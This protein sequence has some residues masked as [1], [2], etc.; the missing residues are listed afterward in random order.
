MY[1]PIIL[2]TGLAGYTQL[3]RT[4]DAQQENYAKSAQVARDTQHFK[5]KMA[6]VQTVDDLM[7]DR[8][9][10]RVALGAFG[11]DEDLN[12]RAYIRKILESDLNDSK[13]LANRLADKRYLAFAKAFNFSGEAPNAPATRNATDVAL[14]LST[15]RKVDDLLNDKDLLAATLKTVGI[16]DGLNND[17]FLRKVLTSD[18][19]DPTSFVNRL[20]DSRYVELAEAFDFPSKAPRFD[21]VFGFV[22]TFRGR[23]ED[24]QTPEDLLGDDELLETALGIFGLEDDIYRT[25]FLTDVLNSDLY[26]E[27]SFANTQEDGRYAAFAKVF[28]FAE[29]ADAELNGYTFDSKLQ[30]FIDKIDNP[31]NGDIVSRQDLSD[32]V[33]VMLASI[34][35]FGLPKRDDR[36]DFANRIINSDRNDPFSLVNSVSDERYRV[37]HD[38]FDFQEKP[39]GRTYPDGFAEA[40]VANYL[41]RQFEISVGEQNDTM[42]VAMAMERELNTLVNSSK[43]NDSRWYGVMA[44]KPLRDVF[45][46]VLALPSDSFGA[47][48]V[49][50]QL[51]DFKAKAESFFGTDKLGD[52]LQED[53]L[54]ELRRMYLVR[55]DAQGYST[56]STA[57][58]VVSL[59]ANS[60]PQNG[61]LG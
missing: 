49:E 24:L 17:Y 5:N 21:S 37:F 39:E 50:R 4:R 2:G 42:R 45:E 22:E 59:L 55:K 51:N 18:V 26:D 27:T 29:R 19:N 10:L 53:K 31:S 57:N 23:V 6:S 47:L 28:G 34:D 12:N 13:S 16:E 41:D 54:S 48:D 32:N 8:Q 30:D 35:F 36:I 56:T 40:V 14:D 43:S 9:L 52:F 25:D 61:L 7:E 38:A 46:T 15:I 44:S 58:V 33:R 1:T 11:L 60:V 3:S 20:G